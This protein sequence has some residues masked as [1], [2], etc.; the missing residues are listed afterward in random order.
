MKR[1][2]VL[3]VVCLLVLSVNFVVAEEGVDSSRGSEKICCQYPGPA[4]GAMYEWRAESECQSPEGAV[5]GDKVV[6]DS[7]CEDESKLINCRNKCKISNKDEESRSKCISGCKSDFGFGN[8]DPDYMCEDMT[9][10]D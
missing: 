7:F 4:D 8:F 10:E 1:V 5:F 6:D 9:Q 2:G 3:L